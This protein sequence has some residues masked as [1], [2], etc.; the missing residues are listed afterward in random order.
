MAPVC[1]GAE[2]AGEVRKTEE[3]S[4][5]HHDW[6]HLFSLSLSGSKE[7][8]T[9]GINPTDDPG[10][11]LFNLKLSVSNSREIKQQSF[12]AS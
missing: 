3:L 8:V 12:A 10:S 2:H 4:S 9:K 11:C 6:E 5:F 1:A 7:V